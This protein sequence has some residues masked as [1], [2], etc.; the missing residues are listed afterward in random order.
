MSDGATA[1]CQC[2]AVELSITPPPAA[3][4]NCHCNMCRGINGSAYTTYAP[5]QSSTVDIGK[6]Q[7]HI[8]QY[9]ITVNAAKHWCR[10]CGTPLFNTN[11]LYPGMTMVYLGALKG[12]ELPEPRANIYCSSKLS[13]VDSIATLKN[14]SDSRRAPA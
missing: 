5:V 8:A 14:F 13:W 6:G 11:L 4:V 1:A 10:L 12:H 2:G 3:A 9:Q 7:E